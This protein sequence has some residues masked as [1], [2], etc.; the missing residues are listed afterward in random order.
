MNLR[1]RKVKALTLLDPSLP[2]SRG[3]RISVCNQH[4]SPTCLVRTSAIIVLSY[5]LSQ[6]DFVVNLLVPWSRSSRWWELGHKDKNA[7]N[8]QC[9]GIGNVLRKAKGQQPAEIMTR[10]VGSKGQIDF[11]Q[12]SLPSKYFSSRLSKCSTKLTHSQPQQLSL[13][14]I[15][16]SGSASPSLLSSCKLSDKLIAPSHFMEV[17][18]GYIA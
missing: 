6:S 11:D 1:W 15:L 2:M 8:V 3:E 16:N 17:T 14:S 7:L 10:F 12:R 18:S 13:H 9:F 4:R 5:Y